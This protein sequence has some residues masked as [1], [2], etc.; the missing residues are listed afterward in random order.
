MATSKQSSPVRGGVSRSLKEGEEARRA[1]RFWH[2]PTPSRFA[3]HLPLVEEDQS[4]SSTQKMKARFASK[5]IRPQSN[6]ASVRR[7]QPNAEPSFQS[8]LPKNT[9]S[10]PRELNA[11]LA[12]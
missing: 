9:A 8:P 6:V 4:S 2:L 7:V 5:A 10:S 3:R 11:S 12:R 1:E